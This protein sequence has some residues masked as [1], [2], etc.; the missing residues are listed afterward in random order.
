M[1]EDR[2]MDNSA[3]IAAIRTSVRELG[4]AETLEAY[5]AAL[6]AYVPLHEPEPYAGLH[7]ER[8]IAYGDDPRQ[9]LD[10]FSPLDGA[11]AP[12]P[13]LAF[14]H[15]GGFVRGDKRMPGAPYYDNAGA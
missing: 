11:T 9:R 7:V 1:N 5:D 6:A 4:D 2:R 8:D 15:G 12:L 3:L 10:V 14:V 13:I